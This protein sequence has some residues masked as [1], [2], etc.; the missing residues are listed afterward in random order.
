MGCWPTPAQEQLLLACFA[1]E[2][3]ALR[4]FD[5]LSSSLT[6]D[7][8]DP[9]VSGLLPLLYRRWPAA[10]RE[11]IRA[12]QKIYL[13]LWRQNRERLERLADLLAEFKKLGIRC[14][15]LKGAALALRYY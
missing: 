9:A 2:P 13:T 5:A 3:A 15:V 8:L 11:L 7:R 14:L 10:G 1:A 12:A 4:S 6:A